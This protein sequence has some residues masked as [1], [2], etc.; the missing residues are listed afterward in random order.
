MRKD[1]NKKIK[2]KKTNEEV[3]IMW[4]KKIIKL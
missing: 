3:I 4:E 1:R 2:S